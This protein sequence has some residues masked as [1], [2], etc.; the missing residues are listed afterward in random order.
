MAAALGTNVIEFVAGQVL[1]SKMLKAASAAA[2]AGHNCGRE[3]SP[4]VRSSPA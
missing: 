1:H 2:A 3:H 4:E